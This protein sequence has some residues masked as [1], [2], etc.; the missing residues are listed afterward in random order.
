MCLPVLN[1]PAVIARFSPRRYELGR[2][3]G[4]E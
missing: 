4:D 1:F 2:V 3:G